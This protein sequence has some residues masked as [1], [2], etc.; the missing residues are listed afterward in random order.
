MQV[1]RHTRPEGYFKVW[2]TIYFFTPGAEIGEP[3][4]SPYGCRLGYHQSNA[5]LADMVN[6]YSKTTDLKD[7]I[8]LVTYLP[9]AAESLW[10]AWKPYTRP[11]VSSSGCWGRHWHWSR[12]WGRT[13]PSRSNREQDPPRLCRQ[14]WVLWSRLHWDHWLDRELW[15]IDCRS[16]DLHHW[17]LEEWA[18]WDLINGDI[19]KRNQQNKRYYC[20][21]VE[22]C[23]DV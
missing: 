21:L 15:T 14:C 22:I 23:G 1:A 17:R 12:P 11:T 13:P 16:W 20:L 4:Y 6:S 19:D 5:W 10:T 9:E 2:A 3:L 7:T 18:V 8:W